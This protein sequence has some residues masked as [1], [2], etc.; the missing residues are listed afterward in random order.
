MTK[1]NNLEIGN[2]SLY[3]TGY[4]S[5]NYNQ[6]LYLKRVKNDDGCDKSKYYISVFSN[7]CGDLTLQGYLY[8][9]LDEDNK[10]SQFIGVKVKEKYRNL[11]IGSFLVASWIDLCMNNG[12]DFLGVNPNQRK[13]FLLY[14]LKT[15]GFEIFDKSLYE[16]RN[17]VITICRSCNM[18]DKRKF[19]SFKDSKHKESFIKTNIFKS[20]NYE[21][22]KPSDE[23][24]CLDQVI[25]PLQS[26]KRDSVDYELRDVHKSLI[27]TSSVIQRHKR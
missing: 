6:D 10:M 4:F 2:L 22:V 15:Y 26:R 17:D 7:I 20:D 14:L 18:E 1:I 27:K 13:P 25:L 21:I 23:I 5:G 9:Y 24:I 11:N 8:F 16:T 19:L 12:Y 3:S